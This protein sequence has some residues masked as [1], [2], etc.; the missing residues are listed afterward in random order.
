M[1]PTAFAPINREGR[2]LIL[3]VK[4]QLRSLITRFEETIVDFLIISPMCK[5][6]CPIIMDMSDF[7]WTL[8]EIISKLSLQIEM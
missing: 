1:M 6:Y 4:Y 7:R 2:Q 8:T 3:V 5:I